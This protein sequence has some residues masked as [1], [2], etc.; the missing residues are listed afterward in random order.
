M[1]KAP[2]TGPLLC[3]KYRV[4]TGIINAEPD[5]SSIPE[6]LPHTQQ[7]LCYLCLTSDTYLHPRL[8]KSLTVIASFLISLEPLCIICIF[9][10]CDHVSGILALYDTRSG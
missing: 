5:P 3:A 2:T 4:S 8:T 1:Y 6:N 10:R 9:N 7:T